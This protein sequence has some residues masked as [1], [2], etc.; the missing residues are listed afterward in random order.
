MQRTNFLVSHKADAQ[1]THN[2]YIAEP[3]N[4]PLGDLM[5]APSAASDEWYPWHSKVVTTL[6]IITNTPRSMFSRRQVDTMLSFL[7]I[8]GLS[9]VP[10]AKTIRA[11]NTALHDMCGVRTFQYIGAHGHHFFV[12]SIADIIS[13]EMANPLVR[14]HLHFYPEDA[15]KM[16]SEYWHGRH[17]HNNADPAVVTPMAVIDG[18]HF[19]VHEPCFLANGRAIMPYR[20]FLR[21]D[22][23]L[24]KA[25]PLCAVGQGD[26]S[27]WVVEEYTTIVI[28]QDEFLIPFN[29]WD[30]S[31][32][33]SGLPSARSIV[34][35]ILRPDGEVVPWSRTQP[36]VGN[37]WR[38]RASGAFVYCF[39]IWLYCDDV[40]GNQ[41]KKWNKHYSFLFSPAGLPRAHFQKEYNVH[42]LCTSNLA[43]PLEMMDRIVEQ[44]ESVAAWDEGIWA[45]DCVHEARVLI[46]PFVSALLGDNPMQSEFAC[47]IGQMGKFFCRMCDVKGFDAPPSGSRVPVNPT[48][49]H[50]GNHATSDLPGTSDGESSAG[51]SPS[52]SHGRKKGDESMQDMVERITRFIN[53]G[54]PRTRDET[55]RELEAMAG[56]AGQVG[57]LTKI[58]AHRTT[59]GI[60]DTFFE[61]YLDRMYL[62]YNDRGSRGEKQLALDLFRA[63]LPANIL[64]PIWRIRGLDPHADTPVE[65]L[66]TVLLGFVKY[67]WRDVV[68]NQLGTNV[69]KKGTLRTR[70]DSLD[71]S[72]LQLPGAKHL[73][74]NT[75]VQYAGSLTGRDFR[76]IA[77]VALFVLYDL[78]PDVCFDAW[79]SLSNLIPIV[80]QAEIPNIDEY[81]ARLEIAI[82]E[83]HYR[84]IRWTPRWFNKAK[85]HVIL[86]LP[87]HVRRFGPAILFATESFESFNAVIRAK[88]IHSNRLAPSRDIALAF[89]HNNRVRHLISGGRH[90]FRDNEKSHRY[91]L[92]F[93]SRDK[94]SVHAGEAGIWCQVPTAVVYLGK[95]L[96]A[97]SS[98]DSADL[99]L[100]EYDT[101]RTRHF[102]TFIPS[103]TP[104][105]F[106]TAASVVLINGDVCFVNNWVLF[107]PSVHHTGA[108]GLGYVREV[109][110]AT[111]ATPVQQYPRPGIILLQQ[112]DVT[113][114][115]APYR[116]PGVQL[117]DNFLIRGISHI[118]CTVNVQH[119]CHAHNCAASGSE[120]VYQ[121]RQATTQTW[122]VVVH[123]SPNDL[124]MST[125]RIHDAAH[126]D[127]LR[128]HIDPSFDTN[129]AII[130]GAQQE[131]DARKHR[132]S[133]GGRG[134]LGRG[135]GSSRPGTGSSSHNISAGLLS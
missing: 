57:N 112:A 55:I 119:R 30:S 100:G 124:I 9:N 11:Q 89:A 117:S 45:W 26:R 99:R 64:S 68:H 107:K 102:P 35:S 77:Q 91:A 29:T 97:T 40:S 79:V 133:R 92:A 65:I 78:V 109:L 116:M 127:L 18:L 49:S 47:H 135:R 5:H 56:E 43:S 105:M 17:W 38:V 83:F 44:L 25:W 12:N 76:I 41:S 63:T 121:E 72:G 4:G 114:C 86:H 31:Q 128:A 62:L 19:F 53:I 103:P 85:Y 126:F 37:R 28:P 3:D 82:Q 15:G 39:P 36:S 118:L 10:S 6:D 67:L 60:K 14:P 70:L 132:S 130:E 24:A 120:V 54:N 88:S 104:S 134:L 21:G 71:I 123:N 95:E 58:R 110:V 94:L 22:S 16:V 106:F 34:G 51:G 108:P 2:I 50:D 81:I 8:N 80:W 20:W 93:K 33:A 73:A 27:G 131:V 59:T 74:G 32:F 122:P 1:I 69:Q 23:I 111:G 7:R 125:A 87:T 13:Q 66:H 52:G 129:L 75:L 90:L 101:P 42:F 46:I 84:I 98:T 113:M 48:T 115:A 61:V 96:S